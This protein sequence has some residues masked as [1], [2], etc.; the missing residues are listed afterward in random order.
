MSLE[1]MEAALLDLSTLCNGWDGADAVPPGA[2]IE[3]TRRFLPALMARLE[4]APWPF[5]YPRAG[6]E[7]AVQLEWDP[8]LVGV[9]IEVYADGRMET[10]TGDSFGYYCDLSP[11]DPEEQAEALAGFWKANGVWPVRAKA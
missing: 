1:K 10:H 5:I 4:G 7:P 9:E 8:P 2:A 11:G 3:R 6:G